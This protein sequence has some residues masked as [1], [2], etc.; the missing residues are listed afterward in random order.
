MAEATPKPALLVVD[1]TPAN[2]EV[3]V[4]ALAEYDYEVLVATSGEQALERVRHA[5]PRPT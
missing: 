4:E 2:L 5:P 1:D 3:L